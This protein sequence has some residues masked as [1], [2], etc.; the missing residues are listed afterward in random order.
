L[1]DQKQYYLYP[2][3]IIIR[4]EGLIQTILGS[5]VAVCLFDRKSKRGGMNHFMLPFWNGEGLE[6]PRYGNVAIPKLI[7]DM[8]DSGS[9]KRDLIAKLFGGGKI[10]GEE[11]SFFHVGEKNIDI[12]IRLLNEFMIPVTASSTGGDRGR[13]IWFNPVTGEVIQQYIIKTS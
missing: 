4:N 1:E 2:S 9:Q 12:A 8:L 3:S 7:A 6:T 11:N 13:K 5:C 10:I